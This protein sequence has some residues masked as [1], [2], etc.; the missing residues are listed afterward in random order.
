MFSRSLITTISIV[1]AA[2]CAWLAYDA[3]RDPRTFGEKFHYRY[4]LVSTKADQLTDIVRDGA[5]ASNF[6]ATFTSEYL[7]EN[8]RYLNDKNLSDPII[9]ELLKAFA[10]THLKI[11]MQ[12]RL[13]DSKGYER[14]RFDTVAQTRLTQITGDSLQDKSSRDYFK[15]SASSAKGL[16]TTSA[17]ELNIEKGV[18]AEP[19]QP[20]VRFTTPIKIKN[21]YVAHIVLNYDF[22]NILQQLATRMPK[23][24][25]LILA[26]KDGS[27]VNA[28]NY[29][30]S[31]NKDLG[32]TNVAGLDQYAP[33]LFKDLQ[34]SQAHEV[35]TVNIDGKDLYMKKVR[36]PLTYNAGNSFEEIDLDSRD[37]Y[38]GV[39]FPEL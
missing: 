27:W 19:H 3:H 11:V 7:Q 35:Q 31:W 15:T 38:I 37:F 9:V 21:K 1:I 10:K 5:A 26:N 22:A 16:T 39:M 29:G 34:L 13:L 4:A 23:N 25:N 24:A 20:T 28:P 6:L 2:I 33:K 17:I 14:I 32:K 12:V 8:E 36:A 18:V 30:D